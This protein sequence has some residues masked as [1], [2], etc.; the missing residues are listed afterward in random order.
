MIIHGGAVENNSTLRAQYCVVGSGMGGA[1]VASSLARAGKDVLLIEAGLAQP[2]SAYGLCSVTA[3]HTGRSFGIPLTRCIELG[4][5]SNAWHGNSNPL[6]EQDFLPRPWL[7]TD[8]WPLRREDLNPFYTKA[9]LLLGHDSCSGL[10]PELLPSSV[11]RGLRKIDFDPAVLHPKFLEYRKPPHRWKNTLLELANAGRLRCLL[12]TCAWSLYR[13]KAAP[14]SATSRPALR[15]GPCGLKRQTIS[16]A[17]VRS[18]P[19][20]CC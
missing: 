10:Q 18:R 16:F 9:A 13:T 5:T 8:G 11:Q 14:G 17:Q 6:D 15:D 19:L 20:A 1:A 7:T 4:G 2:S 12:D 3:E